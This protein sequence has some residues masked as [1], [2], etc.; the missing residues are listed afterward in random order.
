[1]PSLSKGRA[2]PREVPRAELEAAVREAL[3]SSAGVTPAS[4][5]KSLAKSYKKPEQDRAVALLRELAARDD[6][7]RWSK[8]KKE[9]FFARDPIATLDSVVVEALAE[10]ALTAAGLK[11][12]VKARAPGHEELVAEWLKNA[13]ARRVLF[14]QG[15]SYSREPDI[16][17]LLKKEIQDLQ[18]AFQ[19]LEALDIERD[20]VVEVLLEALDLPPVRRTSS[21]NGAPRTDRFLTALNDLAAEN[22]RGALLSLRDLRSR[23]SMSKDEF[24]ETALRLQ[25]EGA[26]SLHHHDHPLALSEAERAALVRD[27][28][29]EHYVGIALRSEP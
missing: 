27:A 11:S 8:G 28:Q 24:D 6:V 10:G 29:G 2:P 22:P 25:R 5:K 12:A 18:K 21:V 26:V 14:K 3:A 1:M 7:H 23:V 4:L 15:N 17:A 13:V 9:V 20:R 19:K 16:R